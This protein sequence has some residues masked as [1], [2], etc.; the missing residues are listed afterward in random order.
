MLKIISTKLFHQRY[1]YQL[2]KV[3][4]HN[5]VRYLSASI[6][7]IYTFILTWHDYSFSNARK[8]LI[9]HVVLSKVQ[10][11]M[12]Y[13]SYCPIEEIWSNHDILIFNPLVPDWLFLS[14]HIVLHLLN[15]YFVLKNL[16]FLIIYVSIL[17]LWYHF[18][19]LPVYNPLVIISTNEQFDSNSI[20]TIKA[21]F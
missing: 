16:F 20:S 4:E 1:Y 8:Q 12:L 17:V 21:A 6:Q 9:N 11:L 13:I 10:Y 2:V 15:S 7:S 19:T 14:A 18:L 5:F 3:S